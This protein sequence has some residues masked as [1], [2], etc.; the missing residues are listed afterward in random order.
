M[1]ET[2]TFTD[3]TGVGEPI[4]LET[5]SVP[6]KGVDDHAHRVGKIPELEKQLEDAEGQTE[7]ALLREEVTEEDIASVVSRWTGIPIDKMMEGEREKLLQMEEIIGDNLVGQRCF[8]VGEK[9][10]SLCDRCDCTKKE[11]APPAGDELPPWEGQN[12][13]NKRWYLNYE[14]FIDWTDGRLVRFQVAFDIT[15]IKNLALKKEQA[16]QQLRQNQKMQAIGTLAGSVAHDLNNI[17]GPVVGYP[18]RE[19][20]E[21]ACAYV[22]PKAGQD[23]TFDEMVEFLKGK[24]LAMY[25]LP[26]RLEVVDE[27]P[28]VGDSGKV[29][30]ETLKKMIEEMIIPLIFPMKI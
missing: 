13:L 22:I 14:R 7:N 16:E 11:A 18:D 28:A 25:K 17:L 21:R 8:E 24:Q 27:F 3:P 19:M 9:S 23:F 1:P 26:E 29:N 4:E 5:F 30:K 10:I 20:G 2:V 12:P 6:K 15:D